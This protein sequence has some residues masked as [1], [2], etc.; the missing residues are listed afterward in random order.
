MRCV[1]SRR[2]LGVA[3]EDTEAE[4]RRSEAAW[5][6]RGMVPARFRDGGG[7]RIELRAGE[8]A[9]AGR[10]ARETADRWR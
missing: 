4:L 6:R 7:P 1:A 2:F 9:A 5:C 10:G 8:G 3:V